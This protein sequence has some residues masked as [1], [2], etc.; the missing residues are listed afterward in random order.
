MK[1][2][3]IGEAYSEIEQRRRRHGMKISAISAIGECTG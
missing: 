2:S 1:L 3:V